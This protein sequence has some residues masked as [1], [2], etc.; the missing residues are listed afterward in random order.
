MTGR[1]K[2]W[3][4]WLRRLFTYE[5][6]VAAWVAG[7]GLAVLAAWVPGLTSAGEAAVATAA[8][9]AATVYTAVHARPADVPTI[10]G[11]LAT[12]VTADAAF[13]FHPAPRWIALGTAASSIVL[14]L[15][16]R[17]NLTPAVTY[18][19]QV[20]GLPPGGVGFGPPAQAEPSGPYA[21]IKPVPGG[22][23]PAA[24]R[25]RRQA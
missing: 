22:A 10:I 12:I 25:F 5:P 24:G 1:V 23:P 4:A 20:L 16:L 21:P 18:R 13:G 17:A 19:H 6:A 7:G 2:I 11:A 14:T 3:W 9:A 8:A 15:A